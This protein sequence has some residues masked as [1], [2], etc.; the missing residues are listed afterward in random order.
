MP[1][2]VMLKFL[3]GFKLWEASID[4]ARFLMSS[5]AHAIFESNVRVIELGCGHGLPGIVA[6]LAGATVYFQDYNEAVLKL[7]TI[8]S[9]FANWKNNL[10]PSSSKLPPAK[11]FSG[12]W[13]FSGS[14]FGSSDS[15]DKFDIVL[16]SETIYSRESLSRLFGC[17]R[18]VSSLGGSGYWSGAL[19]IQYCRPISNLNSFLFFKFCSA[20]KNPLGFAILQRKHF[21]L[22]LE[23]VQQLFFH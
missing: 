1:P 16:T 10:P 18:K 6:L 2:P 22:E 3:G 8:P 11:F 20:L 7:I 14:F 4:L 9:V 13:G 12:D 23:V 15:F 21:T 5:E 17:I 19:L